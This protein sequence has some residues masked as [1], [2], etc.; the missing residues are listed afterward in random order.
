MVMAEN[1]FYGILP[2]LASED[3]P[4]VIGIGVTPLSFSSR[5]SIFYGPRIPPALLP[6]DFDPRATDRRRHPRADRRCEGRVR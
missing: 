5:D 1:C 2:L 4:P 3:R 6:P